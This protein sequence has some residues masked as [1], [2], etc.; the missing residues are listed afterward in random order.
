MSNKT[1]ILLFVVAVAGYWYYQNEY[2]P[3]RGSAEQQW[4]NNQMAMDKCVKQETTMAAAGGM[5]GVAMSLEDAT[6][7]CAGELNLYQQDGHW[8]KYQ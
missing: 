3:N 7:Y 8:K 2:L 4:R 6:E 1:L 5:A